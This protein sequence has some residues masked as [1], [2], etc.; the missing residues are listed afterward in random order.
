[1]DRSEAL[2][3][4]RSYPNDLRVSELY[5]QENAFANALN[6]LFPGTF[7]YPDYAHRKV[8]EVVRMAEIA[9]EGL[10]DMA[11][12]E[13]QERFEFYDPFAECQYSKKS[14]QEI[15]S[16][17]DELGACNFQVVKPNGKII[18]VNK[19]DGNWERDDDLSVVRKKQNAEALA[20]AAD[21][22]RRIR[23]ELKEDLHDVSRMPSEVRM[24]YREMGVDPREDAERCALQGI[25]AR[26]MAYADAE[27]TAKA[28]K[29]EGPLNLNARLRAMRNM[30]VTVL[31]SEVSRMWAELDLRDFL[32]IQMSPHRKEDA[33]LLLSTNM[34][35]NAEYKT[36]LIEKNPVIAAMATAFD[37]ENDR[38][39]AAKEERKAAEIKKMQ[40]QESVWP[41]WDEMVLDGTNLMITK[42][43]NNKMFG[44]TE[45]GESTVILFGGIPAIQNYA[46]ENPSVPTR[47]INRLLAL[48]GGYLGAVIS[49]SDVALEHPDKNRVIV[50][51]TPDE[52][53]AAAAKGAVRH[54]ELSDLRMRCEMLACDNK[55]SIEDPWCGDGE[56]S[57]PVALTSHHFLLVSLGD[58]KYVAHEKAKLDGAVMEV[59]GDVPVG[60]FMHVIQKSG[61]FI[62]Q[63]IERNNKPEYEEAE[64]VPACRP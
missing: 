15:V 43:P 30:E 46:K 21:L 2:K 64:C 54:F 10:L 5:D 3:V 37:A 62:F 24:A 35:A 12:P 9:Y 28:A 47:V 34:A 42:N 4:V 61:R 51:E 58:N 49:P 52:A 38:R 32:K 40:E 56:W 27:A 48:E 23:A 19:V 41:E 26:S 8:S 60:A 25:E 20:L 59:S 1:M 45:S 53:W 55:V 11:P 29:I 44:L 17:C 14:M 22:E 16:V 31:S 18:Q 7:E 63:Q 50:R 36:A 39:I 13:N 6:D 57:G 33:G